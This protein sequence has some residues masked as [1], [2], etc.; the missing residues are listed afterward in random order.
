MKIHSSSAIPW[1]NPG[2]LLHP[3]PKRE[4]GT[5]LH[6]IKFH[7]QCGAGFIPKNLLKHQFVA[8]QKPAAGKL[9][10]PEKS[11]MGNIFMAR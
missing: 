11:Y 1:S 5:Y 7:G 6:V 2:I 10:H 4:Q 3:A 9:I 8:A